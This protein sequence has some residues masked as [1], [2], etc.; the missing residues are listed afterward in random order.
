MYATLLKKKKKFVLQEMRDMFLMK[1][2]IKTTAIT[3]KTVQNNKSNNINFSLF[4]III[5]IVWYTRYYSQYFGL[6]FMNVSSLMFLRWNFVII[7]HYLS[8]TSW[9]VKIQK[10]S[11]HVCVSSDN[12]LFDYD[13]NIIIN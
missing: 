11:T 4:K 8:T 7:F 5:T 9:Y 1:F 3:I 12:T 6:L 13:Y 2:S 10:G